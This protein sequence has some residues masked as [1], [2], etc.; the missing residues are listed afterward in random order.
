MSFF[1]FSSKPKNSLPDGWQNL[2]KMSQLDE[3]IAASHEK[4]QLLFKHSIRC[5]ISVGAMHGLL[6]DWDLSADK[7][8]AWM[9]DLINLRPISNAIAEKTGVPHQS[10]QA[11][12]LVN[13]E[14]VYSKTHHSIKFDGIKAALN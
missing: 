9:L 8:D 6:G 7:V 5:G 14:V 4:P 3:I 1:S 10:P 12:L 11:I 13:G 2:E